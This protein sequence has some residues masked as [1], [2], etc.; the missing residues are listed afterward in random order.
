MKQNNKENVRRSATRSDIRKLT[1]KILAL[2][3]VINKGEKSN[4]RSSK[5]MPQNKPDNM[6]RDAVMLDMFSGYDL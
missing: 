2:A 5:P 1:D 4:Q 3:A 6:M